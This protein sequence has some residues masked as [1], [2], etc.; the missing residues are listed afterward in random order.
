MW[1]L[2]ALQLPSSTPLHSQGCQG[3]LV[4]RSGREDVP[5]HMAP[6]VFCVSNQASTWHPQPTPHTA[7][8][9]VTG[10]MMVYPNE[11]AYPLL[12]NFG[13]ALPPVGMLKVKV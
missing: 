11:F 8:N 13:L 3:Q 12:P 2:D 1:R 10:T 6:P 5:A 9:W 7:I 4:W